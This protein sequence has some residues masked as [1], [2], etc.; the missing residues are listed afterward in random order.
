MNKTSA[1]LTLVMCA[2]GLMLGYTANRKAAE[3][4][5]RDPVTTAA[6]SVRTGPRK[7]GEAAT[8]QVFPSKDTR[9]S[10]NLDSLIAQGADASYAD[11]TL[12][13]V[14]ADAGEIAAYWESSRDGK[15]DGDRERLIFLNWTR[16][17]PQAAIAA[18][19]GTNRAGMP[20]WAWAAS[21]PKAA[22]AS[23]NGERLKDVARGIGEFQPKWLMENFS[24]IPEAVRQDALGGLLT[25]KENED[26]VAT[27]DF[28][29]TQ[30]I[31]FNRAL[32]RTLALKDPWAAYDWLQKNK[33]AETKS[34]GALDVLLETMKSSHPDD[35]NRLAAM[36]PSGALKRKVDDFVFGSLLAKDPEAA[37]V[38]A[39]AIEAPF[40]AVSRLGQVGNSCLATDPEKAFGIGRDILA[41][42]LE[43][44][45]PSKQI[46]L[47]N[48]NSTNIWDSN[49]NTASTFINSLMA[50]DPV[51]VMEMTTAGMKG[52]SSTFQTLC[53]NWSNQDLAAYRNWADS[54]TDPQVRNSAAR[55]VVT[56]LS[57]QGRFEEAAELA[58]SDYNKYAGA[59]HQ[60]AS[61]WGQRDP[62]A[63]AAWLD[64]AEFNQELKGQLKTYIRNNP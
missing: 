30:D 6:K 59:L 37:L 61:D 57:S 47:G 54:L 5:P 13:L 10:E 31:H 50:K 58:T 7:A 23:G 3:G 28:L 24:Q 19:A 11:L 63:A 45:V 8:P 32:F 60:L 44:L 36:T 43:S 17:D 42:G 27:L 53:S 34:A 18:V 2:C 64:S 4:R 20:W 38:R 12:W 9:S 55:H 52:V 35:L 1:T 51:R 41:Y 21:D 56:G 14:D 16:L 25:W 48:G 39:K 62:A 46:D 29:K 22:L 15:L 40:V 49:E 26:P 33:G